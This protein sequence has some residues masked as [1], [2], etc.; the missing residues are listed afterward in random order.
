[1]GEEKGDSRGG[2]NKKIEDPVVQCAGIRKGKFL[3]ETGTG[4]RGSNG[5]G[6]TREK[7]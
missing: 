6:E 7:F 3:G 2:K 4:F 5:N 1:L